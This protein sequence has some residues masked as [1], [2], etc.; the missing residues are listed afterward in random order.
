MMSEWQPIET[1]PKDG[2]TL[3]L[4]WLQRDRV[5]IGWFGPKLSTHGVNYGDD[6]GY[7]TEWDCKYSTPPTHW[8]PLPEPPR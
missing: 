7:G 5:S 8:M 1:A 6:W 4:G 2:T 3:I